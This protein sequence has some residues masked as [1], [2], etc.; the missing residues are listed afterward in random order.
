MRCA[1]GID[2]FL[3]QEIDQE[4]KE[5][6]DEEERN[7]K[8]LPIDSKSSDKSETLVKNSAFLSRF[9]FSILFFI[10][11]KF[12]SGLLI[13]T[14]FQLYDKAFELYFKE[15]DFNEILAVIFHSIQTGN[16]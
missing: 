8:I 15:M 16:E 4:T 12:V 14:A 13:R 3:R 10:L 6:E 1:L 5:I 7:N 9:I 2:L 11:L